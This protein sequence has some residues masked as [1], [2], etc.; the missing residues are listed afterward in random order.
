MPAGYDDLASAFSS[1]ANSSRETVPS[2]EDAR[3]VLNHALDNLDDWNEEDVACVLSSCRSV[4][5]ES[6]AL[7]SALRDV[8]LDG[9]EPDSLVVCVLSSLLACPIDLRRTFWRDFV[10]V[11]GGMRNNRVLDLFQEALERAVETNRRFF[12]LKKIVGDGGSLR[13]FLFKRNLVAWMGGSVLGAMNLERER[14]VKRE[15]WLEGKVDHDWT[16]LG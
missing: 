7:R 14:W 16:V 3:H 2:L 4:S 13:R 8:F 11:G 15:D 6:G 12:A 10:V 1:H 9:F 5:I